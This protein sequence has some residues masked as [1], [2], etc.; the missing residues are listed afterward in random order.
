MY[1]KIA[2]G[3]FLS[4][5]I[6]AFAP[7]QPLP[8]AGVPDKA[9]SAP[10]WLYSVRPG[11]TLISLGQRHLVE[12]QRWDVVQRLNRIADPHRIPPGTVLRI[13]A[14]MLRSSPG[15]ATLKTVHGSVRWREPEGAWKTASTGQVLSV[16]AE[17]Q[18]EALAS[19]TLELANGTQL[20]VHPGSTLVLDTLSLYAN[21]LMA[22]T[23]VRLLRG[24][25]E[26]T[27]NPGKRAQQNLRVL[28]PS[29]Q[30]VV[31]GTV[32]RVGVEAGQ[33]REETLE[34]SVGVDATGKTVVV[35]PGFG[36]VARPGE[37]PLPPRALPRAPD[38][39]G[40]PT[41][42]EQLPLRFSSPPARGEQGAVLWGQVSQ[43]SN[44]DAILAER[45]SAPGSGVLSFA[46]LPNGRYILRVRALDAL[47]LQGLEARHG[48]T[49]AARPF[50]PALQA[51]GRA[52]TVRSP[53][54]A[55]RWTSAVDAARYR[56]Q[57]SK[58]EDFAQALLDQ[59]VAQTEWL[60]TDD[61]PEGKLHWRVASI[62]AQGEQGPWSAASSFSYKP[63]PG[64]PDLG[65]AALRYETDA[66]LLDL[67]AP[68]ADHHYRVSVSATPGMAPEDQQQDSF[69]GAVRLPRPS[70][71]THFLGVRLV[72]NQDGTAGPPMLQKI[73]VPSRH[74][75]LWLLG[76]PLLLL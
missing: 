1:K 72:D 35:G 65:Q 3:G 61:L 14:S 13:P 24:Q 48:F 50:A 60:P 74:P 2:A 39:S 28:T 55:L 36:T 54:P 30:A 56:V 4:L 49:V 5:G 15:Q 31:R 58:S 25:T 8:A 41:R 21:G 9:S 22:D 64:M 16:G 70:G 68:P 34:G 33:T 59:P 62:T 63:A 44:F 20:R 27:D 57:A 40:L 18:T 53:R 37:A 47:G 32:F 12:P 29:A 69:D 52:A 76:L 45:T 46:D 73:D 42:L 19:A 26:I 10:A 38:V 23:R 43:D 71:G 7:A 75:Y 17:L 11:D 51:P 67:P 6:A 66:L